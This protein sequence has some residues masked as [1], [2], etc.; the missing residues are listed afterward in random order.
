MTNIWLC[1]WTEFH[2][3]PR[4]R[5]QKRKSDED[6]DY[7]LVILTEICMKQQTYLFINCAVMVSV[8][9]LAHCLVYI[10]DSYFEVG[11]EVAL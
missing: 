11:K 10:G 9:I 6:F 4:Y 3:S 7:N 8:L 1:I 2:P 5:Q